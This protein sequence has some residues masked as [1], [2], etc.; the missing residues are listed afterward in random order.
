MV[1]TSWHICLSV[2]AIFLRC[3]H[4]CQRVRNNLESGGQEETPKVY[5]NVIELRILRHSLQAPREF[6]Y[7]GGI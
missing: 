7:H 2:T 3:L 1:S 4:L 5:S 6:G